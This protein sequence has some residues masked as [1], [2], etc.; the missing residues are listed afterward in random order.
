LSKSKEASGTYGEENWVRA[1]KPEGKRSPATRICRWG[2][3]IKRDNRE[4]G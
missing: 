2:N 4:I 1:G 3:N